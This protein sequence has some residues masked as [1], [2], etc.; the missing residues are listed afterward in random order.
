MCTA[1]LA[2]GSANA[3]IDAGSESTR[4]GALT[5]AA[6]EVVPGAAI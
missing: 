2:T 1:R 5:D 3:V 4:T 6:A